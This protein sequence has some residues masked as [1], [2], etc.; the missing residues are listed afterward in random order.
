MKKNTK[1]QSILIMMIIFGCTFYFPLLSFLLILIIV[2]FFNKFHYFLLIPIAFFSYNFEFTHEYD[3]SRHWLYYE[4]LKELTWIEFTEVLLNKKD[5]LLYL[6]NYLLSKV[7]NH[8][9]IISF[10]YPTLI[11]F[12]YIRLFKKIN[13]KENLNVT[14]KYFFLYFI[15]INLLSVISGIRSELATV[16]FLN[17]FFCNKK[18]IKKY[19]ILAIMSHISYLGIAL[20][21]Y[22]SRLRLKIKILWIIYVISWIFVIFDLSEILFS[23]FILNFPVLSNFKEHL[24][25]YFKD[26]SLQK[27]RY[28][29]TKGIVVAFY[30]NKLLSFI[31]YN[32]LF[33]W[34]KKNK[35]LREKDERL[36][37]LLFIVL[38]LLNM[39]FSVQVRIL[40][41]TIFIVL[42]MLLKLKNKKIYNRIIALFIFITLCKNFINFY[43][44]R[45]EILSTISSLYDKN[46]FFKT[47]Y[48]YNDRIDT[49][50]LESHRKYIEVEKM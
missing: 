24:S 48:F 37:L 10:F 26:I 43:P 49:L 11:Y 16:L 8:P 7:S 2:S 3:I 28:F 1:I 40:T 32:I 4:V 33:L 34:L 20:I 45:H 5:Y 6:G 39:F 46:I 50:L 44:S 22:F 23:D 25:Y 13:E 42:F 12:L 27:K 36:L 9:Q 18:N 14:G 38:N 19:F 35:M 41:P 29:I 30:L 47:K 21:Y 15:N 17:V 31:A